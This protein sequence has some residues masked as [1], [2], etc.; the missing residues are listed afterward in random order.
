[1]KNATDFE[2]IRTGTYGKKGTA[3][4]DKYDEESLAFRLGEMLKQARKDNNLAQ[5]EFAEKMDTKK[6]ISR[7]LNVD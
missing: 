6:V 1:M 5:E 3:K 4:R 7:E 2:N